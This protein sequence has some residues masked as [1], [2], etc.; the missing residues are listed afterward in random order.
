L[1][2]PGVFLNACKQAAARNKIALDKL[3]LISTFEQEKAS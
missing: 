3:I 2:H 1:F